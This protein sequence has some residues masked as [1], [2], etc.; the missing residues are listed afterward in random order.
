MPRR[1]KQGGARQGTPGRAYGNRSDLNGPKTMEFVGQQYGSRARQVAAQTEVPASFTPPT[2]QA[3][4][5]AAQQAPAGPPP[6]EVVDLFAPTQR[7][8]EPL[9]AGAPFGAGP[10]PE[11][12]DR[13]DPDALAIDRL[14]ALYRVTGSPAL[15]RLL[16][17]WED[18]D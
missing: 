18:G 9:T 4:Q 8:D 6:G 3:A 14:R 16:E 11:V 1:K 17:A 12:L 2:Q 13:P 5:E 10:G 15:G 7:P